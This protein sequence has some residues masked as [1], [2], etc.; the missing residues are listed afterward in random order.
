MIWQDLFGAVCPS[1]PN[2]PLCLFTPEP[3]VE[4]GGPVTPPPA[5]PGLLNL[6]PI[7]CNIILGTDGPDT[8]MGTSGCDCIFGFEGNDII[9]GYQ[10]MS[11]I[12]VYEQSWLDH[13][14]LMMKDRGCSSQFK[15]LP[16]QTSL[17]SIICYYYFL[18]KTTSWLWRRR[19][20]AVSWRRDCK[21]NFWRYWERPSLR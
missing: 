10:G 21:F 1:Q 13:L 5:P 6:C 12:L 3:F 11:S 17:A 14:Q 8:L 20:C 2:A 16:P 7:N 19:W 18:E 4:V 15:S 9:Y